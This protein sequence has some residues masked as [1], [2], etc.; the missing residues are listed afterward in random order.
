M[1]VSLKRCFQIV[2]VTTACLAL[3]ASGLS[4]LVSLG[5]VGFWWELI[6]HFLLVYIACQVL[7]LM[8]AGMGFYFLSHGR[9]R[10]KL[11]A[12]LVFLGLA[13]NLLEIYPYYLPKNNSA[14]STHRLRIL[15][16]NVLGTNRNYKPAIELIRE[17]KPDILVLAEY[18]ERW[19]GKLSQS[20]V[21]R[22]FQGAFVVPYGNDGVYTRFPFQNV[23]VNYVR[24]GQDPTTVISF[25]WR[26][27][28]MTLLILHPR[29]PVKPDWYL[30]HKNHFLKLEKDFSGYGQ[31]VIV[32]GDLNT[33]PWSATFKR[34]IQRTGLRDSQSGFGLQPSW[35]AYFRRLNLYS[36]VPMIP[37]DHVL[38]SPDFRVVDR[39]IGPD[40]SS[41][42]RPVIVDFAMP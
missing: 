29:P 8:W 3:L 18:N 22:P 10:L 33:S 40:V 25:S 15:H 14:S 13:L 32:V 41:D 35:S 11:I 16:M 31:N 5:R 12:C 7:F 26:K 2:L 28:P 36:P 4:V 20:G 9:S 19:Q 30:R 27:E 38:A 1:W 21:L 34:F 24:P 17:V 23:R 6:S 39:R 42:H 37:I